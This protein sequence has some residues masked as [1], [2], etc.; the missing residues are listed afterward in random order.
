[1]RPHS[2]TGRRYARREAGDAIR[3]AAT[4]QKHVAEA[5]GLDQ[6]QVS[7][8]ASGEIGSSVSRFYEDVRAAVLANKVSA[9]SFI[10]GAMLVAE[11]AACSLPVEEV[12]RRYLESCAQEVIEQAAEDVATHRAV[13]AVAEGSADERAALEAQ[14]EAFRRE[15]ARHVDTLVYSRAYRVLRGWRARA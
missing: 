11:E 13:M 2:Q 3:F 1:M 9:G 5:L 8:S 14:D 4:R 7:R 15:G 6:S 10:H 12:K